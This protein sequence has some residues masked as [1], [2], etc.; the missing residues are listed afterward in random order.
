MESNNHTTSPFSIRDIFVSIFKRKI[1][2]LLTLILTIAWVTIG[3]YRTPQL[4]RASSSVYVKRNTPPIPYVSSAYFTSVLERTE[5]IVTE[6]ALITSRAVI[7][8]VV[9]DLIAEAKIPQETAKVSRFTF[10]GKPAALLKTMRQNFNDALLSLGLINTADTREQ[11][12]LS[13]TKGIKVKSLTDSN[14]IDITYEHPNAEFAA[15]VVNTVTRNYLEK[16]I[17]LMKRTGVY[18]LYNDIVGKNETT[19]KNLEREYQ[20][21]KERWSIFSIEDQTKL[22]MEELNSLKSA[23]NQ[24]RGDKA[25]VENK[26]KV[27]DSQVGKQEKIILS[28][29]TIRR[30]PAVDEIHAKLFNLESEK[31]KLLEKF[32][33]EH[34]AVKDI[35]KAI[36]ETRRRLTQEPTTTFDVETV[37]N[38]QIRQEL[39]ATLYRA[40]AELYAK[41]AR[42]SVISAQI[43]DLENELQQLEKRVAALK[44]LSRSITATEKAYLRYLEQ[45]E[46]AKIADAVDIKTSNTIRVVN[47]A[48]V[49]QIPTRSR[50]YLIL[51]GAVGGLVAGGALALTLELYDHSLQHKEDV[52]TYLHIPVLASIPDTKFHY[53]PSHSK[54]LANGNHSNGNHSKMRPHWAR[55]RDKWLG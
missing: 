23:L 19:M 40:Q 49:P 16:N 46:D 54:V 33:S 30:N 31:G 12:I 1:V 26:I 53:R 7:G 9:D 29:K 34:R 48:D 20:E 41:V 3:T 36:E 28:S 17:S 55:A 8:K 4:Y 51:M 11:M 22:K 13:L 39:L 21:N 18:D 27:L 25:E 44:V 6:S 5:V 43:K 10:L 52:E 15:N 38:N 50:L 32:T 42:E 45:R 24:V 37:G 47:F 35:D 14:I 2:I